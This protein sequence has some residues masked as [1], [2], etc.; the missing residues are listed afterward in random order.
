MKKE[1]MTKTI[2][3]CGRKMMRSSTQANWSRDHNSEDDNDRLYPFG[4]DYILSY[5]SCYLRL[6]LDFIYFDRGLFSFV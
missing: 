2:D 1:I 5:F 4:C 6:C 3:R